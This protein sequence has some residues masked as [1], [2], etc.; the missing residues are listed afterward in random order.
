M[1]FLIHLSILVNCIFP[2]L[3]LASVFS[4]PSDSERQSLENFRKNFFPES[5]SKL[6][7]PLVQLPGPEETHFLFQNPQEAVEWAK[8]VSNRLALNL[9]AKRFEVVPLSDPRYEPLQAYVHALWKGFEE[10]FPNQTRGLNEPAVVLVDTEVANAFVPKYILVDNKIA[11]TIVVL[12]GLL[13]KTGGVD[14]RDLLSG[15]FAHELAHSV[16]RHALDAFQ[17]QIGKFYSSRTYRLGFQAIRNPKLD[18]K[19]NEWTEAAGLVGDLTQSQ[20]KNLPSSGVGNPLLMRVWN[21]LINDL[22]DA[23]QACWTAKDTFKIWLGYQRGSNFFSSF[24]ILAPDLRAIARSSRALITDTNTC[25]GGRTD[26]FFVFLSKAVGIPVEQLETIPS[27]RELAQ[28]FDSADNPIEGFQRIVYP[29]RQTMAKI[30]AGIPMTRLGYFTYEEHA[31][32]ISLIIHRYL[33]WKSTSLVDFFNLLMTPEDVQRCNS[34]LV[35]GD[36]PPSG[37]F[38]DQ[39]RS[40]CYR[41]I[42]LHDLDAAIGTQDIRMFANDYNKAAGGL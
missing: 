4:H 13:D 2:N 42:H 39:H 7:F 21:Q 30:E 3:A 1:K 22:F 25:L 16:F 15:V 23:S 8:Q 33:G 38:S 17:V 5:K 29:S 27:L 14:N 24:S 35:S 6:P 31:D 36:L 40:T 26:R 20:L 12:T 37:S 32:D 18:S 11:H 41:I 10:L 9:G 34:I 19:M 28:K